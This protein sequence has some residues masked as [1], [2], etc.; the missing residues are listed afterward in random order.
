MVVVGAERGYDVG[1]VT[2]KGGLIPIQLKRKKL[3]PKQQS[4]SI[5]KGL[6]L[7]VILING[8]EQEKKKKQLKKRQEN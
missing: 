4:F 7:K 2:L 8:Q 6:H 5:F 1:F 3:T